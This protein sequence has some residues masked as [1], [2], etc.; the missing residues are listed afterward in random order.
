M[1][2]EYFIEMDCHLNEAV[3]VREVY[4]STVHKNVSEELKKY[5]KVA[6]KKIRWENKFINAGCKG[7]DYT[8]NKF[9]CTFFLNC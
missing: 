1:T 3:S 6:Y 5:Y 7:A 2:S 4:Y 9:P 8:T